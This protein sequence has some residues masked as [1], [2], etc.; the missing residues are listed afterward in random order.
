[1]SS[2][3]IDKERVMN[4]LKL[5]PLALGLACGILW[6]LSILAMGLLAYFFSY[7]EVFVSTLGTLYVGYESTIIGSILG[8][9]IGF[10]DAFITGVVLAWLYNLFVR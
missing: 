10:V 8:G 5:K 6:G 2:F 4:H 7:G 1:M 9:I 3:N